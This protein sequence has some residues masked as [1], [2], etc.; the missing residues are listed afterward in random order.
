MS[1]FVKVVMIAVD[2]VW[3][4]RMYQ[5]SDI[6]AFFL[7]F[8]CILNFKVIGLNVDRHK[9]DLKWAAI[10]SSGESVTITL[11]S[12]HIPMFKDYSGYEVKIKFHRDQCRMPFEYLKIS[13]SSNTTGT[14]NLEH[15]TEVSTI[16][17]CIT[18]YDVYALNFIR[19]I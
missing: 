2:G 7:A 10:T 11:G 13:E 15:S 4:H 5:W 1:G 8:T 14:E 18:I 3:L 6:M 19:I 9:H 12:Y 17:H 16:T